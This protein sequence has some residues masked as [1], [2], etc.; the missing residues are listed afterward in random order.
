MTI[1][2]PHELSREEAMSRI[3]NLFSKIKEEQKGNIQELQEEWAEYGGSFKLKAMGFQVSGTVE[4]LEK[5]VEIETKLPLALT[6][7]Q[8]A[9]KGAI[10]NEAKKLLV[11]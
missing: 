11:K 4:V 2:T 6:M 1:S 7:F 3:K 8:G 5:S 9:I 10:E